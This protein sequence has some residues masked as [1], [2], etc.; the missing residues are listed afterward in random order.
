MIIW[1]TNMPNWLSMILDFVFKIGKT[2]NNTTETNDPIM[3]LPAPDETTETEENN[4]VNYSATYKLSPHFTY[5]EFIASQTAS[6]LGIDNTP[7]EYQ[8]QNMIALANNVLEPIRAFFGKSVFVSSGYRCPKLN[9]AIG[10][11]RTSQ[12]MQGE[13]ADIVISGVDITYL[14]RW[15]I[16]RSG[17]TYDQIIWEFDSWVHISF[18]RDGRNRMLNTVATKV[19]G[20]THY[21]H[22]SKDEIS[23]GNVRYGDK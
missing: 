14:Y 3:N 16:L 17:I 10:G 4:P 7:N 5:G 19:N 18:K 9:T 12:H 11:S 1:R 23:S 13:A 6:R 8:T 2:Q 20:A 21:Q 15:I 22:Y